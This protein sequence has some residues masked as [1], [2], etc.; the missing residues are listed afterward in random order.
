M[1]LGRQTSDT[2]VTRVSSPTPACAQS[3]PN[4]KGPQIAL[5]NQT[6]LAT[7]ADSNAVHIRMACA[8]ATRPASI[9]LGD[10]CG[11]R[12]TMAVGARW[13]RI[14]PVAGSR[15]GDLVRMVC[16]VDAAVASTVGMPVGREH[17]AAIAMAP[18]AGRVAPR[19]GRSRVRVHVKGWAL[20]LQAAVLLAKDGLSRCRYRCRGC[21]RV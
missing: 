19:L 15:R 2:T 3:D 21:V 18:R 16:L 8:T 20:A 4:Q 17:R 1:V 9:A 11:E 6:C 13:R 5:A 10:C 12:V 14:A 7:G